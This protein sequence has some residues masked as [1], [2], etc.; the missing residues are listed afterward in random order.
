MAAA[1]QG[2]CYVLIRHIINNALINL[3]LHLPPYPDAFNIPT[4]TTQSIVYNLGGL[5]IKGTCLAVL[6]SLFSLLIALYDTTGYCFNIGVQFY[7]SSA[8]PVTLHRF[9]WKS[10]TSPLLC[11]LLPFWKP[12]LLRP[13][14][15]QWLFLSCALLL[16]RP[17]R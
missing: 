11:F 16:W 14:L 6:Y 3:L 9:S 7:Q 12:L 8:P 15:R 2:V 1:T 5:Q 4:R 10:L 13:G 17:P